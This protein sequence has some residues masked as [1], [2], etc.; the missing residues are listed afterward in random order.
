MPEK[1]SHSE[2]VYRQLQQHLDRQPIGFPATPSG[3]EI[4]ILKHI[5]TV[6]QARVAMC[7]SAFA[8][9]FETVWEQAKAFISK[10]EELSLVLS[11]MEKNGGIETGSTNGSAWYRNAP[12]VVG[13]Y[14]YQLARL[15][16]E[17][18]RDFAEYTSHREYGLSFINVRPPQMRTIPVNKSIRV[19]NTVPSFDSIVSLIEQSKGPFAVC[20]CI[21]RKK[22]GLLGNRCRVTQRNETCIAL[23]HLAGTADKVGMGR[24]ID[25]AGTIEILTENQKEGLVFQVSNTRDIDFICSCCGCCCGMLRTYKKLPKPL[26]FWAANYYARIDGDICNRCGQCVKTCQVD[27]VSAVPSKKHKKAPKIDENLCIGCGN[28]V[29]ACK[30]GAVELI[31][32]STSTIP[33]ETKEELMRQI[34]INKKGRLKKILL[35]GKLVKDAL[36]TGRTDI[37]KSR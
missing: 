23:G 5:F 14:E 15:T 31:E 33:P 22:Q 24:L 25:R 34:G 10:P 3:S 30:A 37:L 21:C 2:V 8:Q 32:K 28:C 11:E 20:E 6:R 17:F 16:P 35:Q 29:T 12:L 13:M 18:I 9:S 1:Q 4:R 19:E 26:E 7:L 36:T 27:A